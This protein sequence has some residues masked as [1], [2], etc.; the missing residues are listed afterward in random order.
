M[1]A[2]AG[3]EVAF[4]PD[5]PWQYYQEVGV[6][7]RLEAEGQQ[8]AMA[9]NLDKLC[10]EFAAAAEKLLLDRQRAE[11]N[12]RMR[13]GWSPRAQGQALGPGRPPGWME[14]PTGLAAWTALH[15][16]LTNLARPL[17][18]GTSQDARTNLLRKIQEQ[19]QRGLGLPRILKDGKR[20]SPSS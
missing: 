9:T 13:R 18:K 2:P 8:G 3:I 7:A 11:P 10:T 1:V 14:Q 20:R 5:R 16:R 17:E 19:I 12:R 15:A 4:G 6:T